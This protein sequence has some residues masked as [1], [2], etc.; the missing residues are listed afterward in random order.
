MITAF[1]ER[2]HRDW[3]QHVSEFRFAYNSAHHTSL[4][5]TPAF[6]NFGREP[7]PVGWKRDEV[8]AAVDVVRADPAGWR[9]RMERLELLQ[10]WVGENL[11]TAQQRQAK[12]YNRHHRDRHF[13]VGEQVLKRHRVLS[14]GAQHFSAKLTKKFH[15][16]FVIRRILSP[17]VYE[18]ADLTGSVVGKVH[19]K[20][21]KPYLEPV[22]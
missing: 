8:E 22:D 2:D 10:E 21:L 13:A 19:V 3:D 4:Q 1:I 12:Y 20:D 15:G 7:I 17:V 16:P 14:S 18:L 9:D 6:L 11:E 5:A